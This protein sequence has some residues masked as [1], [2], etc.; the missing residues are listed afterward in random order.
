MI[1][2]LLRRQTNN[3][4][5]TM[6]KVIAFLILA[7]ALQTMPLSAQ[8]PAEVEIPDLSAYILTPLP[9]RTPRISGAKV[10]GLRPGSKCL[11]TIAATGDRPMK[12][13]VENLPKGL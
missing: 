8:Q 3:Y 7:V 11:Y 5:T 10:F 4:K 13:E 12:F 6:K 1:S 2:K 9:A